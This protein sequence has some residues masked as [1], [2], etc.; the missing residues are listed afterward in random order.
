MYAAVRQ[1]IGG[2]GAA[3]SAEGA[4][5]RVSRL[6]WTGSQGYGEMGQ[7]A[8]NGRADTALFSPRLQ[9][10]RIRAV[11]LI[12]T[13]VGGHSY[14]AA[15][16]FAWNL[17]PGR[18]DKTSRPQTDN[19]RQKACSIFPSTSGYSCSPSAKNAD[20]LSRQSPTSH[21]PCP[22]HGYGGDRG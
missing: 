14:A 22:C 21:G 20:G 2:S 1:E 11:H 19:S 4:L 7:I 18:H 3:R 16:D 9:W 12:V 17:R 6:H 15:D 5:R 10:C 13:N 8:R